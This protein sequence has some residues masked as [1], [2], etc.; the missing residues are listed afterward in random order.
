[1]LIGKMRTGPYWK[2]ILFRDLA[3]WFGRNLLT[4]DIKA[5]GASPPK[6]RSV[7]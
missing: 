3:V 4:T 1:M 5:R 6:Y 7:Q 2:I